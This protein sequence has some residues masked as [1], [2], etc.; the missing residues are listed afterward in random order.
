MTSQKKTLTFT[1]IGDF[2]RITNGNDLAHIIFDLC[3]RQNITFENGDILVIA[4]KIVSKAEGRLVNYSQLVPSVQ[5]LEL[6]KVTHKDPRFIELV[7]GES[8]KVVRTKK[9]TLIVEHKR[10][11]ICANA[12]IDHS[13]IGEKEQLSDD[14]A[15]LLP[16]N[17]DE[18]AK[19]IRLEIELLTNRQVGV[20]I[21]DSHGRAWRNGTEGITIGISGVPGVVDLR[22]KKD[23]TGYQLRNTLVAVADELAAGASLLMG[24]SS[25][26]TPVIHVRGF[27]YD[28][29]ESSL[30]ELL[31]PEI[32]DL[33]R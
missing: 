11:F 3:Q 24:Q 17:P 23:L 16:E 19:N 13:N 26:G 18:S 33:F 28:L 6:E 32:E 12:G 15:L 14:W 20:L 7:L 31:R 5:A 9:N 22:G 21:I 30:D 4:Q 2:P 27:P 8:N 10:G 1:A 25:E 29:R